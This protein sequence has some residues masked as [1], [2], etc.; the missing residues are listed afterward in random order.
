MKLK[1]LML[2]AIT[3]F[4]TLSYAYQEV[5]ID[6][7][8]FKEV[9]LSRK[10][11]N[12]FSF[13]GSDGIKKIYCDTSVFN[14]S[15]DNE[16]GLAFIQLNKDISE[17]PQILRLISDSGQIQEI[18]VRSDERLTERVVLKWSQ[19]TQSKLPKGKT[20]H[21]NTDIIRPQAQFNNF[22]SI[23]IDLLNQIIEGNVPK[24]YGAR[25]I[26][27]KEKLVLPKK[28]QVEP[29]SALESGNDIIYVFTLVNT[30]KKAVF[31]QPEA[32][33]QDNH[34]WVFLTKHKLGFREQT[35]CILSVPR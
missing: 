4:S 17:D 31:I 22:H 2:F 3:C 18:L 9:T 29:V 7:K 13:D 6:G 19:E 35:K 21:L 23:T 33:K 5:E 26:H 24:G 12:C 8:D 1:L 34:N 14:I 27:D 20:A 30:G 28:I 16:V 11:S 15:F 25:P 10:G 32:I